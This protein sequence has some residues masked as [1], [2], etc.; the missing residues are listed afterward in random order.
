ME[1]K[2]INKIEKGNFIGFEVTIEDE[3]EERRECF[4]GEE[5]FEK[6]GNEEKFIKKLKGNKKNREKKEKE[7]KQTK[8]ISSI[9]KFNG[10]K[11]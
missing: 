4:V 10:R 7:P 11:I 2:K 6:E 9:T 5:W 3:G 8:K 1:I